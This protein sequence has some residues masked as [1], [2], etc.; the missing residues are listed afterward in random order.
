MEPLREK[1]HAIRFMGGHRVVLQVA[2]FAKHGEWIRESGWVSHSYGAKEEAPVFGFLV[3]A[4]G[5]EELTTFFLPE[6]VSSKPVVREIEALNGQ[7]FEINF[8][9][10]HDILLFNGRSGS[11]KGQIETP[12]LKSDFD[13]AWFRFASEE[14]RTPEELLLIRGQKLELDGR[15]LLQSAGMIDYLTGYSIGDRFKMETK[16]GVLETA[17]PIV[18]LESR[19]EKLKLGFVN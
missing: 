17:L 4:N 18:D 2:A 8:G 14:T 9:G 15:V 5:P 19:L 3:A 12:R 16:D 11:S 6:E 10:K 13:V 7:A 1:D